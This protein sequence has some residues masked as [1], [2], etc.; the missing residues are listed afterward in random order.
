MDDFHVYGSQVEIGRNQ[1]SLVNLGRISRS[2]TELS[3]WY[4]HVE[5]WCLMY[6][7]GAWNYGWMQY[8]Y[9]SKAFSAHICFDRTE[10]ALMFKLQFPV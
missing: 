1:T 9:Q 4:H 5:T 10:D 3:I 6:C 7:P 2:L 8:D